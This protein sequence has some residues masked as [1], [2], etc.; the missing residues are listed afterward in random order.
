LLPYDDQSDK[1]NPAGLRVGFQ[2]VTR[3]GM[4]E[5]DIKHLCDLMLDIIKGKRT[6]EQVKVDVIALK[7]EFS[8][9]KYG[10]QSVEEALKYVKA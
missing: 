2:D 1:E 5:G 9:V 6:P 8:Q 3:H 4:G 7:K 10:F